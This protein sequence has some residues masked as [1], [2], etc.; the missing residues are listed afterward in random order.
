MCVNAHAFKFICM[1][2]LHSL[3]AVSAYCVRLLMA[4]YICGTLRVLRAKRNGKDC[5]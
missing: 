4:T 3:S 2:E 5:T 1:I